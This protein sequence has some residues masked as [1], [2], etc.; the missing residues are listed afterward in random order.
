MTEPAPIYKT[1]ARADLPQWLGSLQHNIQSDTDRHAYTLL[2]RAT[3]GTA[4]ILRREEANTLVR[5]YKTLTERIFCLEEQIAALTGKDPRPCA[6][7]ED[8]N[9]K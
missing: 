1:A 8:D 4:G 2:I 7:K 5:G 9:G 3:Q 6:D